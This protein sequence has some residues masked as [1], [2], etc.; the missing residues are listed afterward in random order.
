MKENPTKRD[1]DKQVCDAI[2][3]VDHASVSSSGSRKG[4]YSK[5]SISSKKAMAALQLAELRQKQIEIKNELSLAAAR[6]EVEMAKLQLTLAEDSPDDCS[7]NGEVEYKGLKNYLN[8][9]EKHLQSNPINILQQ[10]V[11]MKS[12]SKMDLAKVEIG[13]FDGNPVDYWMFVRQF[14]MCIHNQTDNDGERLIYLMHYCKSKAR[15]AIKGCVMLDTD[16]GYIRAREILQ[17]RFGQPHN[18]ARSLIDSVLEDTKYP[19]NNHELLEELATKM[20]NCEIALTQMD[21]C[22]D[23]NSLATLERIVRRLPLNLQEHWSI[24]ADI[25]SQMKREPNFGDLTSFII[26]RARLA[27][28]RFGQVVRETEQRNYKSSKSHPVY[29]GIERP[30]LQHTNSFVIKKESAYESNCV[31]CGENHE[32]TRCPK[33]LDMSVKARWDLL[34]ETGRCFKCLGGMHNASG[35]RKPQLCGKEGCRGRHHPML[36]VDRVLFEESQEIANKTCSATSTSNGL[37]LLGTIPIRIRGPFGEMDTVAFID[38]GSDITLIKTDVISE[39]G[40]IAEP[41][42]LDIKTIAGTSSLTTQRCKIQIISMDGTAVVDVDEAYSVKSLP[43][44]VSQC[45][46]KQ[47][48]KSW[49]HLKGIP[50]PSNTSNEVAVLIGC[51]VPE[52][53]WVYEQRIGDRNQPFATRTPL[54]WMLHGYAG[55]MVEPLSVNHITHR[56]ELQMDWKRLYDQEFA[57]VGEIQE[58]LSVEETIAE[59]IVS[60]GTRLHD[61]R[62]EVPLPWRKRLTM[63]PDSKFLAMQRLTQLRKKLMRNKELLQRYRDQIEQLVTKGYVSVLRDTGTQSQ[64]QNCWYIPH[65]AVFNP[66]KPEKVRIVFDCAAKSRG[67]SLN[68]FLYSGPDT[69][70][71]LCGILMGFRLE[72]V[73]VVADIEEMFLRVKLSQSDKGTLRFLWWADADNL[74]NPV[75]YTLNV[76]PFG[77]TSSPFCANFALRTAIGKLNQENSAGK[78]D[79]AATCFYVDDFITSFSDV[80]I[81]ATFSQQIARSLHSGGFKL[82]RWMS[83]NVDVLTRFTDAEC[84][85]KLLNL[86]DGTSNQRTLGV[87]WDVITD[88][89]QFEFNFVTNLVNRRSILSCV[90]S[91]FD[92]LGLV[93]PLLLPAKVLLQKLCKRGLGWDE[94]IS[95]EEEHEWKAWTVNMNKIRSLKFERCVKPRGLRRSKPRE[96]HV[97][98]DASERGYGV[99]AYGRYETEIS[100]ECSLI[101]GKARVAPTKAVSIPR[102]ELSAAVLGIR[103]Y[104]CIIR[105][106]P[107]EYD[108]VYFWTDSTIVLYYIRN[109]TDRFNTFVANRLTIIHEGSKPDQWSYVNSECNPADVA[110]RGCHPDDKSMHLWLRG[111][112]FLRQ[113][114]DHWPTQ[115][116]GLKRPQD[117]ERK[118]IKVHAIVVKENNEFTSLFERYSDWFKLLKAVVWWLRYKDYLLLISGVHRDIKLMTGMI[119]VSEIERARLS[120]IKL[121]QGQCM[122]N[123]LVNFGAKKYMN[124]SVV[125]KSSLKRLCPIIRDGML[126]V[127]GRLRYSDL[128]ID[129]KYP[130]ILPKCHPVTKLIVRHHHIVEGHCGPKHLAAILQKQYWILHSKSSIRQVMNECFECKRQ[131]STSGQQMM[132]PLPAVRVNQGWRAFEA[133]GVDYFGPVL[134]KRGRSME[135]RYGC[136]FTCMKIRAVHIEISHDLSTDSFLMA[137]MRFISRRGTPS[138]VFSDNGTTFVG[139][140]REIRTHLVNLSQGRINDEM[141]KIGVQWHFNPPFASH[142]GGVWE[143][144]IRSVRRLLSVISG[145]QT[146]TDEM[147]LTFVTEA[148]GILNNRPIV[149]LSDD[150][151]DGPTLTPNDLLL[152]DKNPA[153][154]TTDCLQKRYIQRWK[155]VNYLASIFWTKWTSEYLPLLQLRQKWLQ[156]KRNFKDGDVVLVLS[157]PRQWGRWPL[158]VIKECE[159]DEDGLVRTAVVKLAGRE[160]RRDVRKLA[161]LEGA[162]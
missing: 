51:D 130:A 100:I 19:I 21:Y 75:I 53:H 129:A 117:I 26:E 45:D 120:V 95:E 74:V 90:S 160:L 93:A 91:L 68:D 38:N 136:L 110:S 47:R 40:I 121:V 32:L 28:S 81:A 79:V 144:L 60:E 23:M 73:A 119:K 17:E 161:L 55:S 159:E 85:D 3:N 83:N 140:E 82:R 88:T 134:V 123:E 46:Y 132:A 16:K 2:L 147:L 109:V 57:D 131:M 92:P 64:E 12:K 48:C 44:S 50:F 70:S 5:S 151:R 102:L 157:E 97:F 65:H 128:N 25:I 66:K 39:L 103:A 61:G 10:H 59:N 36:H 112:E 96:L 35:C 6:N 63:P 67:L 153:H 87:T 24:R 105:N 71:N 139:A 126:C 138:E 20:Q 99:A 146:L 76:H 124:K 77:A 162:N 137:F 56:N 62:F 86:T 15:D 7:I 158:G 155:R 152:L 1:G 106:I 69:T 143:R 116:Q 113:S 107:G 18:I 111:P 142:R 133:V 141:L 54:G 101:W 27:G 149:S 9:C 11:P 72:Q 150:V 118:T 29:R 154:L 108:D 8:D 41:S 148:E 52:A 33:F 58:G 89:L 14:D 80:D 37:V 122:S 156:P 125:R 31:G 94:P 114:K 43:V 127:G 115:P 30:S 78:H 145:E 4:F 22:A 135:K 98:C 104:Q 84:G 42:V 13:F 49:P 34:K